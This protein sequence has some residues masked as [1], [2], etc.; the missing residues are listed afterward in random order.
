MRG[1]S[2]TVVILVASLAACAP[3]PAA[4]HPSYDPVTRMLVRLDVDQ[5][6]D[7]RVD[8]RTYLLGN[9]PLRSELDLIGTGRIDRWEYFNP[10][11]ALILV[12]TSSLGDG[13][14][15]TWTHAE[16]PEGDRRVDRSTS[17][18]R[19]IDRREYY[20]D[21]MLA[22]SEEDVNGDGLPDKWETYEAGVL[23]VV[24]FDTTYRAGRPDRRVIYGPDG[25]F[26]RLEV[27]LDG[28]GAFD[29]VG[30]EA[31]LESGPRP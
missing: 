5:D 28:D 3:D 2:C 17:R 21:D 25:Q 19:R 14:E 13:I 30:Q 22:R 9:R 31:G 16:S 10:A 15:D 1:R 23:R 7:G 12:G 20:R 24:A 29:P 4:P 6:A 8:A 18:D 11:G 26:S 27:D